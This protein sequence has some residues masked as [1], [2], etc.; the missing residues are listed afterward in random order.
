MR[1][2]VL[3]LALPL[4]L[5]ACLQHRLN[6]LSD[7]EFQH[8]YALKPFMSEDQ[9]SD[10]LKRKTEPER[11]AYLQDQKLWDMFYQYTPEE[12]ELIVAGDVQEG[13]SAD[14]VLMSWGAPWDKRKLVGRQAQRSEMLVY[15]FETDDE[16]VVR[17]WEKGSKTAYTAVRRFERKVILDDNKVT[18]VQETEGWE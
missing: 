4:V 3:V 17:I 6:R 13:W 9:Q 11:N 2:R 7:A 1:A 10:F 14:K 12:R 16:G 8:Y 5:G 15:R 18:E